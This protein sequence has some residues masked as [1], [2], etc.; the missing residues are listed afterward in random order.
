MKQIGAQQSGFTLIELMVSLTISLILMMAIYTMYFDAIRNSSLIVTQANLNR[1]ARLIFRML[2][3]GQP[4]DKMN[5][6]THTYS[7]TTNANHMYFFGLYGRK[8]KSDNVDDP[9]SQDLS[10]FLPPP[11]TKNAINPICLLDRTD[12]D[13]AVPSYRLAFSPYWDLP[14]SV[15]SDAK[16]VLFSLLIP[17]ITLNCTGAG[18][19]LVDCV[20]ATTPPIT[21]TGYLRG[22][23]AFAAAG[24]GGVFREVMLPLIDAW[25]VNNKESTLA[26]ISDVYWSAFTL[27]VELLP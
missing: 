27:N 13:P 2:A 16:P 12:A 15:V 14:E 11:C 22:T 6:T 17:S 9:V 3:F 7:A 21:T 10:G 23:P 24:T 8:P 1:E 26:Q 4:Y 18:V 19:P 20:D 25:A 5:Y